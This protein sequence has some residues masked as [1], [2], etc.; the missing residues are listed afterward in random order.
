MV[1]A[2]V[3]CL[4]FIGIFGIHTWQ[5]LN[6]PKDPLR[7]EFIR[8]SKRLRNLVKKNNSRYYVWRDKSLEIAEVRRRCI[9]L[10]LQ[11]KNRK[12]P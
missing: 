2:L 6:P 11:M 4:V 7:K 5:V 9:H 3:C 8:E 12:R 10:G 1:G